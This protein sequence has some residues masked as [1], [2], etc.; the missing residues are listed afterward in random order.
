MPAEEVC[1]EFPFLAIKIGAALIPPTDLA[2]VNAD[3]VELE[4]TLI[5]TPRFACDPDLPQAEKDKHL[6]NMIKDVTKDFEDRLRR[7]VAHYKQLG[8]HQATARSVKLSFGSS[9]NM[10]TLRD[11]SPEER[12][13]LPVDDKK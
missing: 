12:A 9:L 10:S 13:K 4:P 8:K 2:Y 3:Q 7:A 5:T 6:D 11:W 1:P